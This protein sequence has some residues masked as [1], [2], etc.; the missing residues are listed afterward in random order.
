M[1]MYLKLSV[2]AAVAI[3]L[4]ACQTAGP[5]P[6][7]SAPAAPVP[8]PKAVE[9]TEK[10]KTIKTVVVKTPVLVKESS[11]FADGQLDEY[12]VYGYS[13]DKKILLSENRFDASRPEAIEKTSY[14]FANG[15]LKGKTTLDADG[16]IKYRHA[17][18]LDPSGRV[19][20]DTTFDSK[21]RPQSVSRYTFMP[22]GK[23][24]EWKTLDGS[25]SVRATTTYAY[26][27]G[28]L[29]RIDMKN[30][31]GA[32]DGAIVIDYDSSARPVKRTYLLANGT[33]DKYETYVYTDG[34]L[35]TEDHYL[36]SGALESRIAYEYDANGAVVRMKTT[37]AAG[38]IL[39]SV[40]YEYVVIE[41]TKTVT[42]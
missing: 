36:A 14:E 32:N 41:T 25:G 38:K 1:R 4:V 22:D 37:N 42:E 39:D 31:T 21:N 35:T 16:K 6:A 10:P 30:S 19:V 20:V 8:A 17:Y 5:V 13:D 26:A 27:K 3:V 12:T 9:T 34:K 40:A 28:N 33:V 29:A 18:E 24:S 2:I 15:A 23:R 7:A 11:F